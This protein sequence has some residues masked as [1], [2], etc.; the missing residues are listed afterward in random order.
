MERR[1]GSTIRLS[2]REATA[3]LCGASAQGPSSVSVVQAAVKILG[4][5][6]VVASLGSYPFLRFDMGRM[7]VSL[8]SLLGG[9]CGALAT[10]PTPCGVP[11]IPFRALTRSVSSPPVPCGGRAFLA[12]RRFAR[13]RRARAASDPT[14]ARRAAVVFRHTGFLS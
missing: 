1:L 2:A 7:F 9:K 6:A 8:V 13:L 14:A 5:K 12:H 3:R 11:G 10:W 4:A